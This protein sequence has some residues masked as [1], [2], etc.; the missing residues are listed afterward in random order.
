MLIAGPTEAIFGGGALGQS[1]GHWSELILHVG[2][3]V[4]FRP[5]K[6]AALGAVTPEYVSHS[7]T[8]KSLA[9]SSSASSD[10]RAGDGPFL[11]G[12]PE[13]RVG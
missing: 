13:D 1:P 5:V 8:Y 9:I 3:N 12:H 11:T 6:D 2:G 4:A 10:T 7:A